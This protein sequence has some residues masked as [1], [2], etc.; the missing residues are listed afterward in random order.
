MTATTVRLMPAII[1]ALA[2]ALYAPGP[3]LA[4]GEKEPG[5]NG[6]E[7][8]MPGAFH[9]EAVAGNDALHVYLL[10]MKFQNPKVAR[11]S[12]E[13]ELRQRDETWQLDCR[14]MEADPRFKCALPAGANLDSGALTVDATR[15][16][17][18]GATAEYALPLM[19]GDAAE[20]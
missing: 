12:V 1:L 20:S 3:A 17:A 2:A 19:Q 8:R 5:P 18:P 7:I 10:D 13:A 11:S 15:G 4:H 9:V 6:G 14:A 16:D